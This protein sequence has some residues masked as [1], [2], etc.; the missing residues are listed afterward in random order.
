MHVVTPGGSIENLGRPIGETTRTAFVCTAGFAT[1]SSCE[2]DDECGGTGVCTPTGRPAAA[3]AIAALC[4]TGANVGRSCDLA[5]DC[6]G[7]T[8]AAAWVAALVSEAAE[9]TDLD[10]D[11]DTTDSVVA[12]HRIGDAPTVWTNT[13]EAADRIGAC[14]GRVV[15][16]TPEST[17]GADRNDDGD[18]DDRVLQLYDPATSTLTNTRQAAHEFVERRVRRLP[19]ARGPAGSRPERRRRPPRSCRPGLRSRE[20]HP[21]EQR[22]ARPPVYVRRLRSALPVPRRT[23]AA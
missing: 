20:R 15:F 1:G 22:P 16:L 12:V 14:G 19:H 10:D 7:G 9:S 21:A 17:Q 23:R 3:L 13:H 8:C 5:A 11:G 18:Q 2:R 4:T 6:P